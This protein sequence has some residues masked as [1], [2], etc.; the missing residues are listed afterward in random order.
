MPVYAFF[1][2]KVLKRFDLSVAYANTGMYVVWTMA[3][4]ALF[5]GESIR[6]NN[7]LGAAVVILG[8]GVLFRKR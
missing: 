3:W 5:F 8:V 6:L 4:A 1:W 2:Q 7:L